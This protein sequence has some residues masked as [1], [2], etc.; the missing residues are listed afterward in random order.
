MNIHDPSYIPKK[1]SIHAHIAPKYLYTYSFAPVQSLTIEI[2]LNVHLTQ[3]NYSKNR[4][5]EGTIV[6]IIFN[7]LGKEIKV[8]CMNRAEE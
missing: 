1:G 4:P 5:K 6:L 7:F 8:S 3:F 2:T